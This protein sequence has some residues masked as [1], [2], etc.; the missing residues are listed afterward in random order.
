MLSK[1]QRMV[2]YNF[3]FS[4]GIPIMNHSYLLGSYDFDIHNKNYHKE[5]VEWVKKYGMTFGIYEG[6]QP[7]IATIDPEIIKTVTVKEFESFTDII[8]LPVRKIIPTALQDE[9]TT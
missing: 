7:T 8:D 1:I 9:N 6:I 5:Q 3:L 2:H 4:L